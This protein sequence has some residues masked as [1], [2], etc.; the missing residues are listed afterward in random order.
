MVNE[1][2]LP[3]SIV[4][5]QV[6]KMKMISPSNIEVDINIENAHEYIGMCHREVFDCFLRDRAASLGAKLIN[7]IVY[8]L[9]FVGCLSS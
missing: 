9:E 8:K 3:Q 6:R 2:D 7:G 4:D 1:F 5:R